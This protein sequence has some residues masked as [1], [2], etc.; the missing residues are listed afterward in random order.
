MT[1]FEQKIKERQENHKRI[2]ESRLAA[3]KIEISNINQKINQLKNAY[4]VRI[5]HFRRYLVNGAEVVTMPHSTAKAL[6]ASGQNVE[7]LCNGGITTIEVRGSGDTVYSGVG[8]CHKL[9]NFCRAEGR[10]YAVN[11][12]LSKNRWVL[13]S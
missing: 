9:D 8:R 13:K 3:K 7:I 2:A 11:D 4:K 12:L 10:K 1:T 6:K 5:S